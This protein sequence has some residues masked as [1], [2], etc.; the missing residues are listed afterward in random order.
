MPL[1]KFFIFFYSFKNSVYHGFILFHCDTKLKLYV[2]FVY[3]FCSFSD[4]RKPECIM[5]F[6]YPTIQNNVENR[7]QIM[8]NWLF[9]AKA[10]DHQGD[11]IWYWRCHESLF[12]WAYC[13]LGPYHIYCDISLR[14]FMLYMVVQAFSKCFNPNSL[15]VLQHIPVSVC[16]LNV[17]SP[18]SWSRKQKHCSLQ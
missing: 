2:L 18:W 8:L 5:T 6:Y 16:V 12:L 7:S 17:Y 13:V 10:Y 4:W 11:I 1:K 9:T 14:L 3:G 15:K